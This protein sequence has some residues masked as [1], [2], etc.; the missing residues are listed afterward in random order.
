LPPFNPGNASASSE[1]SPPPTATA[2]S[3]PN[4]THQRALQSCLAQCV[5][6]STQ[7]LRPSGLTTVSAPPTTQSLQAWR[8]FYKDN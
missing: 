6:P 4:T 5:P 3:T 1:P 8:S 2:D 7:W